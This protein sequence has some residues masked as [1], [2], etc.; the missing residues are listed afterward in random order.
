MIRKRIKIGNNER[1]YS[2]VA[3]TLNTMS[4]VKL[5]HLESRRRVSSYGKQHS[6]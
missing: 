2:L 5:L 6:F 4:N 1:L 3:F